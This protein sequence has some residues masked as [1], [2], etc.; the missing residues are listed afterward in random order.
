VHFTDR[1]VNSPTSWSWDFG[2]GVISIEKNPTHTYTT[3]GTY[4]AKL[5]VANAGGSS[6]TSRKIYVR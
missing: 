5:T 4:F 2:D 1:S 3:P 6:S